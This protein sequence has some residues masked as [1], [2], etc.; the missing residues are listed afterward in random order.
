MYCALAIESQQSLALRIFRGSLVVITPNCLRQALQH[1]MIAIDEF[2][3]LVITPTY[4]LLQA[5]QHEMIEIEEAAEET[6]AEG[7]AARQAAARH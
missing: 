5:L 4:H 6:A 3:S 2:R 1:E 7:R